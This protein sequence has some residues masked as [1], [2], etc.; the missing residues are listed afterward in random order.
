MTTEADDNAPD[1]T[2]GGPPIVKAADI[3][4]GPR[5]V[6]RRILDRH[7]LVGLLLIRV[8]ETCTGDTRTSHVP[9]LHTRRRSRRRRLTIRP[10][11][12]VV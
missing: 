4:K 2:A 1:T 3:S 10:D 11:H 7:L 9:R 6:Q 5:V 8:G 12:R